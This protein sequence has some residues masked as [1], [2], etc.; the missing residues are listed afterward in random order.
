MQHASSSSA[1]ASASASSAPSET[2]QTLFLRSRT[3]AALA[4]TSLAA[5]TSP[6]QRPSKGTGTGASLL[7]LISELRGTWRPL[8]Q[9][10]AWSPH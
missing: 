8:Q 4:P 10:V 1:S 7:Q 3:L 5:T 2:T 9:P 6:P